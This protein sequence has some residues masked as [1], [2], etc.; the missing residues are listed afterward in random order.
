VG[1]R[2]AALYPVDAPRAG[3]LAGKSR[4]RGRKACDR[5]EGERI[6]AARDAV[7][8]H[9]NRTITVDQALDA[10][11]ADGKQHALDAAGKTD[12]CAFLEDF[13]VK[14]DVI[15]PESGQFE[16]VD[17]EDDADQERN[18]LRDDR[19]P[20]DARDAPAERDDEHEVEDDIEDRRDGEKNEGRHR[21]AQPLQ[22]ARVQVVPEAADGSDEKDRQVGR[23]H[24]HRDARGGI[25]ERQER[26]REGDTEKGDGNRADQG[27]CIGGIDRA[28]DLVPAAR[29]QKLGNDDGKTRRQA[30]EKG[31]KQEIEDEGAADRRQGLLA[32]E[33]A[34][35]ERVDEIVHLLQH[36]S[37]NE[38][39]GEFE[40]MAGRVALGHVDHAE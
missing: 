9:E 16:L 27:S 29:A 28:P 20:G 18:G 37:R 15:G 40:D 31:N 21:V 32:H 36:V 22:D 3:V 14:T 34:D 13:G 26:P 1:Y 17:D 39:Q 19:G 2:K 8:G 24:F 6:D 5:H 35:D 12:P 33:I 11:C 10:H 25:H 4:Y 23:R 7:A 30:H 38:R